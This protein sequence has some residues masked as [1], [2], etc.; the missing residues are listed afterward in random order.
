MASCH[1]NLK[2]EIASAFLRRLSG[3]RG[4][5]RRQ[6]A[7]HTEEAVDPHVSDVDLDFL[8]A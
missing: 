4:H 1:K 2:L 8:A 3:P 5:G 7:L 6:D